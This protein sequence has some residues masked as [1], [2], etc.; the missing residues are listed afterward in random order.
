M[1][2]MD[3]STWIQLAIGR[4]ETKWRTDRCAGGGTRARNSNAT[5]GRFRLV[6]P[7]E[8]PPPRKPS[9]TR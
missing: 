6:R 7:P 3:F 2:F 8:V 1:H 4:Y 9:E 5:I